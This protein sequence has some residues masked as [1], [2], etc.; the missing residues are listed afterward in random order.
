MSRKIVICATLLALPLAG[1]ASWNSTG[2][3]Y[4]PG[5]TGRAILYNS[6]YSAAVG[7]DNALCVEGAKTASAATFNA[8]LDVVQEV[9]GGLGYGETIV[10]L[11][12]A[13]PQTTYANNAYFSIC[14]I[15]INSYVDSKGDPSDNA[16][17]GAQII[18]LFVKASDTAV[19]IANTQSSTASATSPELV[20][21][22]KT[23]LAENGVVKSEEEIV[24]ELTGVGEE[25]QE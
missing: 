16:L 1:C 4:Q 14:Q 24:A 9:K 6:E 12:P 2:I 8:A 21:F 5:S 3:S 11:N 25:G 19:K 23:V 13:N 10:V 18:Q 17:T 22:I 7:R 20:E 15:A